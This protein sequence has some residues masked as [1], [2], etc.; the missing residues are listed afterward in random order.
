MGMP[1]WSMFQFIKIFFKIIEA[2]KL[3][4]PEY[5]AEMVLIEKAYEKII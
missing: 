2:H 3:A 5:K 1:K 4:S